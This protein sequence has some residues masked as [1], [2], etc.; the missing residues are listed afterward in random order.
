MNVNSI[1]RVSQY[2]PVEKEALRFVWERAKSVPHDDR[3]RTFDGKM[4]FDNKKYHVRMEFRL[5]GGFLSIANM[6]VEEER[7]TLVWN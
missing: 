4:N 3:W 6:K 7:S 5:N 2:S 1:K